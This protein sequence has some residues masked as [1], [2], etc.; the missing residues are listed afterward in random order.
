M[1]KLVGLL[2]TKTMNKNTDIERIVILEKNVKGDLSKCKVCT[3]NFTALQPCIICQLR[4][5]KEQELGRKL[6]KQ[7]FEDLGAWMR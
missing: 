7:E 4:I 1:I 6:T 2:V 3:I 5:E